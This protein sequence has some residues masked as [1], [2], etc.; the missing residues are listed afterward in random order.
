MFIK[1][2]IDDRGLS[3]KVTFVA[4]NDMGSGEELFVLSAGEVSRLPFPLDEGSE[5]DENIYDTLKA[6]SER[7][8]ALT[9][10]AR[11]LSIGQRSRRTLLYK[12][13]TKGYSPEAAEHAVK[14]LEKK[15]YLNDNKACRDT[16]EM[17]LK[18]KHYGRQRIVSYLVSHGFSACDAREAAGELDENELHD[19]LIYN[20]ERKFPD[21]EEM[22]R[23]KQQKA[24]QS[25]I[26]L[27]FSAGEIIKEVKNRAYRR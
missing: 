6:A 19:A 18:T 17:L 11:I 20:I 7:T 1:S 9:E 26:R 21:I 3:G 8:G 2:V 12:L 5:V 4:A 10:A 23:D 15:G 24:V 16:A 25:L 27:G 22:P 13:K 14:I